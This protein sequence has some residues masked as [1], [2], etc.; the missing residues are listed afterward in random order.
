MKDFDVIVIGAGLGG[1][2]A[3]TCLSQAGKRVLLLEK[4]NVP[5]GYASS[6]LRGRFEFDVALH[7]LSGV[8]GNENRGPLW[9][10]LNGW[11]VA[12]RVK[13]MPVPEFYRCLFP[14]LDV[15]LPVGRQNFEETLANEFPKEASGIKG[16]VSLVFD[17]A[18]E[19]MRANILGGSPNSLNP[20]EFPR[21]TAYSNHTV[22]QVFDSFFSDQRI[23]AVLGQLC[24]YLGQ[25]PSKLPITAFAMAFTAYLTYGP[26]HIRGTSQALSQAFVDVIEANGGQVWL[27]KGAA[28]ILTSGNRVQGV[29]AEDGTKIASPR[30]VCNANPVVACLDLIGRDKVPD[31]Y[32]RRLGAWSAG[33]STFNVYLGL[34][35]TCQD[36]GLKTHETFVGIDFNLDQHDEAALKAVN[37]QPLAA[38]VTA[39]NLADP[40]FSPPGTASVVITLGAHGAPWL[41]LSPSEYLEAKSGLAVKAMELA[42]I[43]A[44][45][46]R[47][48]IEVLD[49]ATPLTNTRYTANP[50]GS[51]T[52]FAENRQCSPLGRLPSRGPLSGLYFANAWVNIGGGFMPCILSG[53]L[54]AQDL[55]EDAKPGG[56]APV[57][58]ERIKN[59]MEQQTQGGRTLTNGEGS[60]AKNIISRLHP[61]RILL[62]VDQIAEETSS[63]KTLRMIP[64]EG[65]LPLFRPGQ[66]V[67]IF[68][69]FSGVATSRPYTISSSLGKPYWDITVRHKE[70]G[71]VSPYLMDKVKS[72]DVLEANGPHGTFYHEPLMDSDHLVFLAGGSGV[73]P[74]MSIIRDAVEEKRPLR[75]HLLYGSRSPDDIIFRD[76]L[77][78]IALGHP[79]VKVDLVISGPPKGWSGL[80][81]L[82]DARMILSRLGSV[83][84]KTFFIC[85]PARM[86]VLCEEALESLGVPHRRIKKE[87]YGPPDDV[88][89]EP[90]WPGISFKTAFEVREERS[91]RLFKAK[92]GEPLMISLERAGLVIP[93]ACRSGECTVC[94][95]RLV[96]GKVFTPSRVRRRWSDE[97]AGYIHP[98]LSYP[99][100]DL[101]IRL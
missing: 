17:I 26:A 100:E 71:L 40:E 78:Q 50:G 34:D 14:G 72:G 45:D 73:T 8:G 57:V 27:N 64:A 61:N 82:L 16:F 18:E 58:M 48:H 38:A 13:F 29:Q 36:L 77:E 66:Y 69:H 76:E 35:C 7:E 22:A 99:L 23:R 59:Q 97:Q 70:G 41:Q 86:H 46:L 96:S 87:A 25:P 19:A 98:C 90:G 83:Q 53:F 15:I 81:G 2:S 1:L 21:M 52:G 92:A 37:R 80:C 54:A 4:H 24:N 9:G 63:A 93:S 5:G 74:F 12:P 20:P 88:T 94:R 47:N 79:N 68:V 91:G 85:G 95:T 75:I 3:A 10:L 89:L 56:P 30:V 33:A 11:G 42:E 44:P 32:L 67:H 101:H 28:R 84:G 43:V 55:L 49:I 51:F 39:Y 60:K 6:F 31:W 62:K 65:S